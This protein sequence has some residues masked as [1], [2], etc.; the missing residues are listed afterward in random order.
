MDNATWK[1]L[2]GKAIST[3]AT[4][5]AA[6]EARHWLQTWLDGWQPAPLEIGA[7]T[8]NCATASVEV[9]STDAFSVSILLY[10][11]AVEQLLARTVEQQ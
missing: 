10:R 1:T 2:Q 11:P 3:V 5:C 7:I 9:E 6:P 8:L 4:I